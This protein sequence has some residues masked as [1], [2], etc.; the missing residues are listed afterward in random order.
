VYAKKLYTGTDVR[1]DGFVVFDEGMIVAISEEA[2]G[3]VV[4]RYD[5]ITPAFVDPHC[6]I[7]M[8]RAGE[9]GSENETNEH[10]DSII[11]HADALDSVQM[12]DSSFADSVEAGVMYSCVT[13]G[14]GNIVGGKTVVLRNFAP[15]THAAYVRRAGIKGAFGYNPMSTRE[16]KGQRPYTRMGALAILRGKL[17]EV[18]QK[19]EKRRANPAADVVLSL[20]ETILRKLLTRRERFRVHV[21][22]SDDVYALLR[23]VDEFNLDITVE[24]ACDVHD[25]ET[26]RELARRRIPVVFGPLDALAYKVELKH[27]HW[28]NIRFLLDSGVDYGLMT[29][30]PVVLQRTLLLALRWFIRCGLSAEQAIGVVTNRNARILGLDDVLGA[31]SAGK[32]ASFSCWNGEPFDLSSH[33]VA[34][35]GEGTLVYADGQRVAR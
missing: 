24:H 11:A 1:Q 4:G 17:Y 34:G 29:D 19:I 12:D 18:K 7:G 14:S 28:S 13:P 8:A 21:H 20:E 26:F 16:W 3:D 9:P 32:W 10:L 25:D 22:K 23:I 6:H 35:Y 15:T 31:L 2:Q 30:H 5:C 33:I 27:E